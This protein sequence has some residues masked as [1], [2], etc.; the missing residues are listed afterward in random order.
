M[1][2]NLLSRFASFEAHHMPGVNQLVCLLLLT[3][4]LFFQAAAMEKNNLE[5]R[6]AK[7][8]DMLSEQNAKRDLSCANDEVND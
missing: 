1:K 8:N 7:L 3:L 5:I 4:L 6:L 2:R